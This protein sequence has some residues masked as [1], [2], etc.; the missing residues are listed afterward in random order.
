MRMIVTGG[1]RYADVAYLWAALDLVVR[2][3]EDVVAVSVIEGAS[4]DVTGPYL[5]ADYWARQWARARGHEE[6]TVHAEWRRLGPK[7]GPIR[8]SEM[9]GLWPDIVVAFPGGKGTQDM[10]NKAKAAGVTVIDATTLK[11]KGAR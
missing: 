11:V 4:D 8:N 5:G 9:L 6:I 1:R 3:Q 2:E 7:A 10:I